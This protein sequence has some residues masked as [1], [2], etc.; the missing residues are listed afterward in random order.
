MKGITISSVKILC[1]SLVMGL[2]A[3]VSYAALLEHA[4]GNLS[5]IGAIIIGAVVYFVMIYFMGIEEVDSMIG[6]V[7]VKLRD[8]H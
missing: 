3:R 8:I 6:A 4:S 5:L 2:V 1:V 7:K